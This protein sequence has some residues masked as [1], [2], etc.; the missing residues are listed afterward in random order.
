VTDVD[1]CNESGFVRVRLRIGRSTGTPNLGSAGQGSIHT[2]DV[3]CRTRHTTGE[4]RGHVEKKETLRGDGYELNSFQHGSTASA[5]V[6]VGY[7]G[8]FRRGVIQF[9]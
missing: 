7:T 4:G 9:V 1:A 3:E 6:P 8:T 5:S 2:V